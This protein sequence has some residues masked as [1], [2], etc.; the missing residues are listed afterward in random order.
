MP[1]FIYANARA[2]ALEATLLG[3]ERLGRMAESASPEGAFKI[4]QETGFGDGMTGSASEADRLIEAEEKKLAAFIRES[5]P[6]KKLTHFLLAAHDFHNAEAFMR[7]KHL[8]LDP[9]PMTGTEGVYPLAFLEEKIFSDDYRDFCTPLARALLSADELFLGGNATGRRIGT[10]FSRA[11]FER[12][13]ELSRGNKILSAIVSIRADAANIGICLR[14]ENFRIAREMTVAGGT[15]DEDALRLLSEESADVIRE[16]MR[17]SPCRALVLAA[18]EDHAAGRPLV[19]LER[20]A[21]SA[22]L[23]VLKR[24]KYSNEGS[25]PFLRYCCYREA[26]LR[27]VQIILTCLA[28][29][30]DKSQIR[31]RMR[32]TYEG[33]NGYHR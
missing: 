11:M 25:L 33:K 3:S 23:T 26:E 5:S 32:E 21:D 2:S 20:E 29:G 24:D 1:D 10:L 9:Q 15:L 7:A 13:A 6:D 30:T 17:L 8:R 31:A 12:L 27:N 28:N 16:R 22:A 4:L 19:L 14:A 18:L